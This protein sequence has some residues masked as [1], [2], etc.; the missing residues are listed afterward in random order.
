MA[1]RR[2]EQLEELTQLD[3]NDLFLVQD[4][5]ENQNLKEKRATYSSLAGRIRDGVILGSTPALPVPPFLFKFYELTQE[6]TAPSQTNVGEV[7]TYSTGIYVVSN[8]QLVAITGTIT[9]FTPPVAPATTYTLSYGLSNTEA[10]AIITPLSSEFR[11]GQSKTI[12]QP[13]VITQGQYWILELPVGRVVSR[14]EDPL[15]PSVNLISAFTRNGQRWSLEL[16]AGV[17]QN[18][19]IEVT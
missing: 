2:L 12:S 10:G 1:D 7:D 9:R 5:S 16:N 8:N 19:L 13:G 11:S 15:F 4:T 17:G 3:N 6:V 14:I 18:Y